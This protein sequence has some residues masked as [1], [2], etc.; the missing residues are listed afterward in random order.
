LLALAAIL[1]LGGRTLANLLRTWGALAPG[2]SSGYHRA[3]SHRHWP[4]RKLARRYL[5]AVLARFVPHGA[6]ELAGDDTVSKHPG[7]TVYGK[8]CH[9]DTIR[10]T[11]SFTAYRWGHKWVVVALLVRFP[12]GRRGPCR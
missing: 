2:H 10:S 9:R 7:A 12:F 6:A 4:A 5:A 11:R 1:T 8:G 3:L